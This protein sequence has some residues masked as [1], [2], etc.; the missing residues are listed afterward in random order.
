MF[1]CVVSG[2]IAYRGS[3]RDCITVADLTGGRVRLA[4]P[5]ER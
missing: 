1:V 2:A 4:R 5:G 3:R